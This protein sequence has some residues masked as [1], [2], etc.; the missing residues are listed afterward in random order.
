VACLAAASKPR[1]QC[2][3]GRVCMRDRRPEYQPGFFGFCKPWTCVHIRPTNRAILIQE[4]LGHIMSHVRRKGSDRVDSKVDSRESE[5]DEVKQENLHVS[6]ASYASHNAC[7]VV[8]CIR[9]MDS[10]TQSSHGAAV[11]SCFRGLT[12]V[13]AVTV[14]VMMC[15]GNVLL[16]FRA[17]KPWPHMI[18]P[19]RQRVR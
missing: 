5:D 19:M 16:Y 10:L 6:R 4:S 17:S 15:L 12:C 14:M 1:N 9:L 3:P 8:G 13:R 11:W 18:S 7:M 2:K